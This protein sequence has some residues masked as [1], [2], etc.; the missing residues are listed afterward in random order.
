VSELAEVEVVDAQ[1]VVSPEQKR[2]AIYQHPQRDSIESMLRRGKSASWISLW[3]EEIYPLVE[4][5]DKGKEIGPHPN[6]RRHKR[7]HVKPET[8]ERY[9]SSFMPECE[10]GVDII[11][12]ELED[13][14]GR[15]PPADPKIKP[16]I[17]AMEAAM[18]IAEHN[19]TAALQADKKM[20]F[21]Q[22]TTIQAQ[23][24]LG[25]AAKDS[26]ELKAKL[27]EEGYEFVAEKQEIT[28]NNTNRNASIEL[29]GKLGPDGTP[30]PGDPEKIDQ[31]RELLARGPEAAAEMITQAEKIAA[32]RAAASAEVEGTATE[33]PVPT[34]IPDDDGAFDEP[35]EP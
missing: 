26:A 28:T 30:L 20:G 7:W 24:A 3:L 34:D 19:V 6:R 29:Y 22:P 33:E 4:R 25:S 10:P 31:V 16:E 12:S 23:Q 13:V 27:G 8:I 35:A 2:T 1:V 14:I 9:R 21:V 17:A 5:N 15:R 18:R 11:G 32:D